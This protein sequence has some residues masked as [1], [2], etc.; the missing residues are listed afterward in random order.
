MPR[1]TNWTLA[2]IKERNLA[3]EGYCEK[4]GCGYFSVFNVDALIATVGPD[5]LVPEILPG[6]ECPACGGKLL[7]KL[8]MMRPEE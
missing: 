7:F 3:L 5:Y 1:S 2:A 4:P 8:A 6:A